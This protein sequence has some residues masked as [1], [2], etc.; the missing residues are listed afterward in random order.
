MRKYVEVSPETLRKI[1]LYCFLKG[2][3]LKKFVTETMERELEPYQSWFE[4]LPS[5]A[6][7]EQRTGR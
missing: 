3:K 7:K 1:Q 2:I 5:E 6:L 4:N